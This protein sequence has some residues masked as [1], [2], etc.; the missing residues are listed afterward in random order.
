MLHKGTRGGVG[1]IP[2]GVF[3]IFFDLILPA[4]LRSWA[5]LSL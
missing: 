3:G 4:E 1:S 2:D 5:R